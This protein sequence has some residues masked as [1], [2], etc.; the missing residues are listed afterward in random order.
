VLTGGRNKYGTVNFLRHYFTP[1]GKMSK[2]YIYWQR[3]GNAI[4]AAGLSLPEGEL[5]MK[6]VFFALIA[7][8]LLLAVTACFLPAQQLPADIPVGCLM[9]TS[10]APTGGP[11]LI[12]AAQLAVKEINDNGGIDGKRLSLVVEDEGPTAATALYAA[13]KLVDESRVQVVIGGTTS[14][15]VM[16]AGP[17]MADKGVV[18]VSPSATSSALGRFNWSGWVFR[19]SPDDSLQGGVVAKLITDAGYK[20]VAILVVDT[21]YGQGIETVAKEYLKGRTQV[22][23]SIRYD[24][25][26]LSYFSELNAI[27][28]TIPSCVLH[29][30]A[31]DDSAVIFQQALQR[32]MDNIPWFTTD[33]AF[34]L[35]LD[36]YGDAAK[37]MEKAVTGTVPIP[38][39]ESPTYK[40]FVTAY[41]Y[42]YGLPPTV[43]CDTTYDAVNMIAAALKKANVYNGGAIKNALAEVGREYPGTSGTITFDQAGGRTGGTYGVW[44]VKEEG[45]QY[46]FVM[47]G[48]TVS[49]LKLVK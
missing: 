3:R 46:T 42:A 2:N 18:M 19:V 24:P 23:S 11:N 44:K 27:K 34:D 12:K 4:I 16:G 7:T 45:M 32:G 28:D 48:Q 14:E 15:A 43:Y 41:K 29:A 36:K 37:F 10:A 31:Y 1:I 13:H 9:A 22:V 30:G 26:K 39:E 47:T 20:K 21:I 17:Y 38:D 40:Y 8:A 33:G 25:T 5:E 49:F 6:V 35:P